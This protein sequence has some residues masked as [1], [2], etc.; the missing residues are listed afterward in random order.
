MDLILIYLLM[1]VDL[2]LIFLEIIILP[3]LIAG[4]IGGLMIIG[5]LVKTF[6]LNGAL[7]GIFNLL[8]S[9]IFFILI[10]FLIRKFKLWDR[11]VL[12]EKHINSSNELLKDD[13]YDKLLNLIGITLTQ[14]KP[15]CYILVGGKKFEAIC[16]S[17]FI[18]R[19]Q[20]VKVIS[21]E[22]SKLKVINIEEQP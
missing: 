21:V 5:S 17:A 4:I 10:F 8:I 20:K 7:W 22:S 3:D 11:L 14:L 18:P 9:L 6:I 12:K 1:L 16:E 2:I 13:A 19:N 15:S